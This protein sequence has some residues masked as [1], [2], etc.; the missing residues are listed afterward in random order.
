[1]ASDKHR[2][3]LFEPNPSVWDKD[4]SAM[5]EVG[6]NLVRTGIWTGWKK[7]MT[8]PGKVDE[9]T[10]R[11]FDA[12]LLTA[13]KYDIPVIFTFFA[14]LPETWVGANAYLDPHAFQA[15]QQFISAFTNRCRHVSSS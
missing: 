2:R 9:G 15:Q 8:E 12:F 5:K 4:F 3:F 1:M 13:H 11:A 7:Y 14:F 6:V 10:L